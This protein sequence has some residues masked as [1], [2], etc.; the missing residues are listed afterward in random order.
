MK[1]LFT[2]ILALCI[3]C[4]LYA[5]NWIPVGGSNPFP[6]TYEHDF[7]ILENN[8]PAVAYAVDGSYELQVQV[9]NG[10]SWEI[11]PQITPLAVSDV[12]IVHEGNDVIVG[13]Y[14]NFAEYF[15][16]KYSGGSWNQ[17]GDIGIT[18]EFNSS[19]ELIEGANPG[20]LWFSFVNQGFNAVIKKWDGLS[21][22]QHDADFIMSTPFLYD[23]HLASDGSKVYYLSD[24]NS[25]PDSWLYTANEAVPGFS[26]YGSN[27]V[28]TDHAYLSLDC[29]P[30]KLPSIGFVANSAPETIEFVRPDGVGDFM[31]D[32]SIF[33]GSGPLTNFDHA[34]GPDDSLFVV[35]TDNNGEAKVLHQEGGIM[36]QY[37]SELTTG[38][39]SSTDIEVFDNSTRPF[40]LLKEDVISQVMAFN[41]A[42]A[43]STD[44]GAL[45]ICQDETNASYLTSITFT[46]QDFDSVYVSGVVSNTPGLITSGNVF[47]NRTNPYSSGS[48][49]NIFSID[50][51]PET[52]QSGIANIDLYVTDG[53]ETIVYPINIT[54]N[55][56]PTIVA[57][58]D[59]SE[60][61]GGTAIL[62]GSGGVSYTWD[63]GVT[64]GVSFSV[65]AVGSYIYTVTGTDANG[66]EN[67]DNLTL[68]VNP[69]PTFGV[70]LTNVT[71]NG[72]SDGVFHVNGLTASTNYDLT[73]TNG[74]TVGPNTELSNGSGVIAVTGFSA[75]TFTNVIITDQNGCSNTLAGPYT[76]TEP[77][78]LAFSPSN[79][80][81]LCNGTCDGQIDLTPTGGIAPYQYS[82]NNGS[83]FQGSSSFTSLC[84]GNYDMLIQDANGCIATSTETLVDPSSVSFTPTTTNNTCFGSCDGDISI[85]ASGGTAPYTYSN[86]NGSTYQ[87]G[88]IFTGLCAANYDLVVLDANGCISSTSTETVTEPT[89]ISY[90]PSLTDPTCN[91]LCDGQIDLIA[92]GGT[93]PYQYSINNGTSYQASGTFTGLCAGNYDVLI[94]DAN[95]CLSSPTVESLIE[96]AAI[97]YTPTLTDPLCNGNCDGQIDLLATGGT[98]P[99]QYS[100]NNGSTYQAGTVFSGLCDGNYD[101][102][103]QD[104]NGCLSSANIETLTEPTPIIPIVPGDQTLCDGDPTTLNGGG[105]G[106][107]PPLSYSWN[108]GVTDGVPFSP[109]VGTL[110]YTL[111]V[112]DNNGCVATDNLD[113]TVNPLPTIGAGTDQFICEGT[114]ANLSGTGGVSYTWDNSVTDGVDFTPAVGTL[115]YTVTGV[116]VNGC[117]NTDV[118]D[119]TVYANPPVFTVGT[120]NP[121]IC[122]AAD[123]FLTLS[124]LTPSTTYDIYYNNG[125][126]QGPFSL[127]T[128]GSGNVDVNGIAAGAITDIQVENGNSCVTADAG[129]YNLSDPAA[130][131]VDAGTD[132]TICEGEPVV[133]TAVNSENALITWDNGILNGH[134]FYPTNTTTYT[135]I[136]SSSGCTASDQVT[137]TVNAMPDIV[138][139]VNPVTCGQLD[140]SVS[141]SISN[142]TAPYDIYWSNGTTGTSINDLFPALYYINVTDANNCFAMEVATVSTTAITVSGS[143]T[144]NL[145]PGDENG[146]ID[147]TVAGSGPFTYSWS[148]GAITEDISGLASGQYEVM[149]TDG[150]GCQASASFI[151]SSPNSIYGELISTN[152][153][154]GVSD[155]AISSTILGGTPTYNYQW[156]DAL[157]ADITGETNADLNNY[158]TGIYRLMV[159]DA[160]GCSK[161]F[162]TG[163]SENNGPIVTVDSL[164]ASSCAADGTIN[165]DVNS[166]FSIVGYTWNNGATTEDL[167]NV[168][169]GEYNLTVEDV[170]GCFGV[171][172]ADLPALLPATT[173]ICIVSVDTNTNTN[174]IVWEKPI[175]DEIA[176]FTIYRESSIA[177]MFQFVDN[178]AYA[179]VSEYNDTIAYPGLRSWRYRLGTVDTCGNE[180]ILSDD[181]KTMHITISNAGAVYNI[182]WDHYEGFSYPT[183]FIWRHTDADGWV[184]I[185]AVP[186]TITTY[187]ETPPSTAGIDYMVTIQPPSTCT[188]TLK[189]TDYNSSRSNR[190]TSS[191]L[192]NPDDDS[193][194]SLNQLDVNVYPN[195][196][197]GNF[198]VMVEGINSY[199]LNVYD[200]SGKL[201][202]S[203]VVNQSVYQL[204]LNSVQAGSYMLQIRTESGISN[205]PLIVK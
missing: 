70:A 142:G 32:E 84:A 75:S 192:G 83:T 12:Q 18:T 106:G 145:C 117:Q 19:A 43:Y 129:T 98:L 45:E 191:A 31:V 137:V 63:N 183:Y 60:C 38:N 149:I 203:S 190:S 111:T 90:S 8:R 157:G 29:T 22:S 176:Y 54:V 9:W 15:V 158:P 179:D 64:D 94:L 135:V 171:L 68:T 168:G 20:E 103:I 124:G 41:H 199:E 116:D 172:T 125:S 195:P 69:N 118:V 181:H 66:C 108:Q 202:L 85:I 10:Q 93:A 14:E 13:F 200:I 79:T 133:L 115:T 92:F 100:I 48:N 57:G 178:V 180:S 49:Q 72:L 152:A 97:T 35:F 24:N 81:P 189:A 1:K 52:S 148:N 71:C 87:A 7:T 114:T 122:G 146:A 126:N 21:W 89:A 50:V 65:P 42:P 144:D 151:I 198:Q 193:G 123:G 159:T 95:G 134:T 113:I 11:L 107:T 91:S 170:N 26:Q 78:L 174:L 5:Q 61:D 182:A 184:Q 88:N 128:D 132:I 150:N 101:V 119:I 161:E 37:G 196:S 73:Y 141:S 155:G 55:A 185:D 53:F 47:V 58:S 156:K 76:I 59:L 99:Y 46:D 121:T 138:L 143:T 30:G 131:T 173:D 27:S 34:L 16:Y 188:S 140:G 110:T 62:T 86:N 39:P 139:T 74:T 6:D 175:T 136:A 205:K 197:E 165:V 17:V 104:A 194:L 187:T 164:I 44:A 166:A 36:F 40:V 147:L 163:I 127:T 4:N 109:A 56:S 167:V 169:S 154:C 160:N 25:V 162:F 102:L 105:S 186:S 77:A 120:T 153:T 112:T 28:V 2:S 201:I 204:D 23:G 33:T 177:G 67:T 51:T 130:P 80:D 96:P 3:V 82:N